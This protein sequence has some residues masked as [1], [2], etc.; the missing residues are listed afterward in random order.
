M[1]PAKKL[2]LTRDTNEGTQILNGL[3]NT[4]ITLK[5]TEL[6]LS[7]KYRGGMRSR[8]ESSISTQ[9]RSADM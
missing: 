2:R 5:S 7:D 6:L 8:F 1:L 9:D 4:G 3:H